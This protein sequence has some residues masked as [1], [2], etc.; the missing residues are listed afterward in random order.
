MKKKKEEISYRCGKTITQTTPTN[1]NNIKTQKWNV[2]K[3]LFDML[4]TCLEN[5]NVGEKWA[6]EEEG[7]NW[8]KQKKKWW[9]REN[10]TNEQQKNHT[11]S[12]QQAQ[13]SFYC[14]WNSKFN[15]FYRSSLHSRRPEIPYNL[16]F[17]VFSYN[18]HAKSTWNKWE[19]I[20]KT[21][22]PASQPT[23][24]PAYCNCFW[25]WFWHRC[26]LRTHF[27]TEP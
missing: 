5:N 4:D 1:D 16:F 13:M 15:S 7:K 6:K 24:R 11:I 19:H 23:N 21:S 3:D 9:V 25:V 17:V 20:L 2:M 22:W 12:M 27:S 18:G 14:I 8:T 26:T 10:E